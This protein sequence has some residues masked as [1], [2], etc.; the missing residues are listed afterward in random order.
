MSDKVTGVLQLVSKLEEENTALKAELEAAKAQI[1]RFADSYITLLEKYDRSNEECNA[2]TE[3]IA[4]VSDELSDFGAALDGML[5]SG[6][7]SDEILDDLQARLSNYGLG[8][9]A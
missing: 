3:R 2:L 7:E 5:V 6:M 4:G 9:A 8:G 1:T